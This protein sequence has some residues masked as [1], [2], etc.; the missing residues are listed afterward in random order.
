[1][2]KV[3]AQTFLTLDGVMEAPEKWQLANNLFDEEMGKF[4]LAGYTAADALLLG[5]L[6]Y[7]EFASFWPS[8]SDADPFAEKINGLPKFVVSKTLKTLEWK[9]SR[10]LTGD[11]AE[12]V[13]KLKQQPGR[14]ILIPGSAQLVSGLTPHRLVDE[15]QLLIHPVVVGKGKRLFKEG[16]EPTLMRLVDTKTF[17]TGAVAL[18]YGRKGRA[19][20]G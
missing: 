5:R 15:Y 3:V 13:A 7:Q 2:R 8:Q 11:V 9:N 16:I 17:G 20:L 1:M 19:V 6:T 12:E 10:L 14:D 4:V 18:T